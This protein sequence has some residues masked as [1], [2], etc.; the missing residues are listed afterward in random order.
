MK[1]RLLAV[2]LLSSSMLFGCDQAK[3]M[4]DEK[5]QEVKDGV[6]EQISEQV[7]SVKEEVS[8]QVTEQIDAV[9]EQTAEKVEEIKEQAKEKAS[10][11]VSSAV[12][13]GTVHTVKMKNNN[14]EGIM[15]FEPGFLKINKGDTVNF[16]A[17]DAGHNAVSEVTTGDDWTVGFSGGK[18]TFNNEGVNIYYCVPHRSMGMY[19]VI[20]VGEATNKDDAATKAAAIDGSFAMNTGRLTNYMSQVK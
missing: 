4:I 3:E 18:V 17:T 5:F 9:K 20:Q 1:L 13:S 2:L 8:E 6:A 15:V 14:A 10:A 11:A 12:S 7:E 19:G 16:I